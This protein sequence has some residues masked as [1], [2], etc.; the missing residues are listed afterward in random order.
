M[1]QIQSVSRRCRLMSST[2]AVRQSGNRAF[3]PGV[4]FVLPGWV[5]GIATRL[6]RS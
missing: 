3:S 1:D 4:R 5:A 2:Q 6:R